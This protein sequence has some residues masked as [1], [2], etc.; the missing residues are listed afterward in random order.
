MKKYELTT[1]TIVKFGVNLFQIRALVSFG[2]VDAGDIGGW[3]EKDGNLS[4]KGDAWLY[5]VQQGRKRER[6]THCD[7][8]KGR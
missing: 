8:V 2:D 4:H 7:K 5:V 1:K 6:H 3:V